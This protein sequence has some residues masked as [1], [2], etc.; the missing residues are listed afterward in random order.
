MWR[1]SSVPV[2]YSFASL[3]LFSHFS[4][5]SLCRYFVEGGTNYLAVTIFV[6]EVYI[7]LFCVSLRGRM[8]TATCRNND[9]YDISR[10]EC[11]TFPS[12]GEYIKRL[13]ERHN[14]VNY[15]NKVRYADLN[16]RLAFQTR[17]FHTRQ[18][19]E[20]GKPLSV[21]KKTAILTT[22]SRNEC[23]AWIDSDL[24]SVK[25]AGYY[26]RARYKKAEVV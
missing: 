13:K 6:S 8:V 7:Y 1:L 10:N 3:L 25:R 5:A 4:L 26:V 2:H 16:E 20:K 22:G 21:Y 19:I 14:V 12:S 24:E 17:L 23:D 15:G 18:Y 11:V 9:R